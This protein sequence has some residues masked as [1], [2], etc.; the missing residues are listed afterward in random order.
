MTSK[1]YDSV[2]DKFMDFSY[3]KTNSAYM[4]FYERIEKNPSQA[5]GQNP[6]QQ[7]LSSRVKPELPPELSNWIWEDNT[8]FLKDK[9]I[10]DHTYFDFMWQICSN[11]PQSLQQQSGPSSVVSAQPVISINNPNHHSVSL[12]TT[13]LATCF[14]LETLIHSKEKPT[15]S[16]WIELLTKQFNANPAG[17]GVASGPHGRR[18]LVGCPDPTQVS[19]SNGQAAVPKAL[20]PCHQPTEEPAEGPLPQAVV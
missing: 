20:H 1:T 8:Q 5:S 4:L 11:I 13:K 7:L 14:V 10:F 9:M 2:T 6:P 19:Q 3:E 18:P 16:N 15:L 17:R 12:D